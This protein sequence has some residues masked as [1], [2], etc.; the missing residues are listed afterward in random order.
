[1]SLLPPEMI[2]TTVEPG[3]GW[4]WPRAAGASA[5]AGSATM[6][7]VWY[8]ASISEQIRPVGTEYSCGPN[9]ATIL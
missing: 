7:S 4:N 8:S 9:R 5:P 3:S 2:T 6:P 1:M